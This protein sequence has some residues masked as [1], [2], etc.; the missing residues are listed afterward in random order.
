V[1]IDRG[2]DYII[3]DDVMKPED[4]L[5][6]TRRQ[7]TNDWCRNT[8]LSRLN[9]KANG[10]II[11]VMQRLHEDDLVGHVLEQE[12]RWE[13]LRLPAIAEE[14]ENYPYECIF[15]D[16]IFSRDAGCALHPERDSIETLEHV[17]SEI[18]DY[19]FESQYQQSPRPLDGGVIKKIWLRYYA[20]D[21]VPVHFD[22][23]LQSWDTA[24]KA[25]ELN[26][27]SVCTTWGMFDGKFYLLDVLRKRM[28]FP[29]LMR[30]VIT[31]W[32]LHEPNKLL[33]EDRASGTS[34][35]QELRSDCVHGIEEYKPG[36]V[37]DK[38]MR[39][40]AESIKFE[41]GK[42]FLP[43]DAHWL[44]EYFRELT[45]FPGGRHDDQV[46]STSQA[47]NYLGEKGRTATMWATLGRMP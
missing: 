22:F 11:I 23:K 5:S 1:P 47:L 10:V 46:D 8:L 14:D 13:I 42:V 43:R 29:E 16:E 20:P 40:H 26:D 31:H 18:R 21:E 35:I 7:G 17:R 41:S 3:L 6:G 9:S 45:G 36:P 32:R 15:G 44:P 24:N 4:A 28:L 25:G 30:T 37:S 39:L 38:P 2:A 34:L 27:F 33:I 19:N 12:E